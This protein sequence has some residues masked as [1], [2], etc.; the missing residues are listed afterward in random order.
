MKETNE[1]LSFTGHRY[2]RFH[3]I[4]KITL[5]ELL[6]HYDGDSGSFEEGYKEWGRVEREFEKHK[7]DKELRMKIG[8]YNDNKQGRKFLIFNFFVFFDIL[9]NKAPITKEIFEEHIPLM[10]EKLNFNIGLQVF[11]YHLMKVGAKMENN[12]KQLILN[13]IDNDEWAMESKERRN[14]MLEF[15]ERVSNYNQ[16]GGIPEEI[17]KKGL[18]ET[19]EEKKRKIL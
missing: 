2:G 11:A 4:V 1:S 18:F 8:F 7:I 15:R 6:R 10:L 3:D 5:C 13:A 16:Q 12:V 9:E 19:I 14:C 17:P